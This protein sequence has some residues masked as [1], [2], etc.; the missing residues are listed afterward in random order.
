MHRNN[1]LR[2]PLRDLVELMNDDVVGDGDEDNCT[3][4]QSTLVQICVLLCTSNFVAV[5]LLRL[6]KKTKLQDG[7]PQKPCCV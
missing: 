3:L 2:R 7:K 4:H 1:K 5:K 6:K